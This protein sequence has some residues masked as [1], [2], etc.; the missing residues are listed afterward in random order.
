MNDTVTAQV[1]DSAASAAPANAGTISPAPASAPMP[2][3]SSAAASAHPTQTAD[4]AA[5]PAPPAASP[6][7]A[8]PELAPSGS[9]LSDVP[10]P[11]E[12]AP[13]ADPAK[14]ADAPAADAKPADPADQATPAEPLPAPTYEFKFP[15]DVAVDPE[16]VT[17]MSELIGSLEL[18]AKLDHA[19]ASEFGQKALDFHLAEMQRVVSEIDQQ[20]RQA[21]TEMR[22]GWRNTFK[23]D[24]ELGGNRQQTTLAACTRVID[25]FGGSEQQRAELRQILGTTGAG[26]HPALIRLLANVGKQLGEGRPVPAVVP[27]SPVVPSRKERRYHASNGAA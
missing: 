3:D 5:S 23:S 2:S 10:K 15:E 1:S 25:Q 18:D 19:K 17:K 16:R 22:E 26:D 9:L 11:A 20:G 27:K 21:W 24:P 13:A 8:K 6:P 12:P 4:P 7:A 14:P